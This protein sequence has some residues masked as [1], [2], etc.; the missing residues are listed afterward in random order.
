MS[1]EILCDAQL[2][3]DVE[4][5]SVPERDKAYRSLDST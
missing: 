3:C 5:N 1:T 2:A 4:P